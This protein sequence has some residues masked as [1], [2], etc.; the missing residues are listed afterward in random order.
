M[1]ILLESGGKLLLE[2]GG[3]VLLE[4]E[5]V[6]ALPAG[7]FVWIPRRRPEPETVAGRGDFALPPLVCAGEGEALEPPARSGDVE[8]SLPLL[9]VAAAGIQAETVALPLFAVMASGAQIV[10]G[11]AVVNLSLDVHARG[12][13]RPAD[14][15]ILVLL[16][17]A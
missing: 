7:G 10:R 6:A 1:A 3:R 14:D 2:D 11:A 9:A 15:E 13:Q 5:G 16:L 17:A 8:A 12:E 4:R